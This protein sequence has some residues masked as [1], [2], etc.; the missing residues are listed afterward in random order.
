M[1]IFPPIDS[2]FGQAHSNEIGN[3]IRK[4][5]LVIDRHQNSKFIDDA[6][7]IIG[8]GRLIKGDIKNATETFKY[9][10][11]IDHDEI[12]QASALIYLYQIYIDQKDFESAL[13]VE[14]FIKEVPLNTSQKTD[15]IL[16][17]HDKI[18]SKKKSIEEFRNNRLEK[19]NEAKKQQKILSSIQK[20][21]TN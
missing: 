1:A 19:V 17:A 9:I 21:K 15:F 10:N 11:S 14:N 13:N 20:E 5:S 6:Y 4:A 8:K 3:L 16:N 7:L 18:V 12:T 2:S